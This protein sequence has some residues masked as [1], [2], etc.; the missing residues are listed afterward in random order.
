M[1]A[2]RLNRSKHIRASLYGPVSSGEVSIAADDLSRG[3]CQRQLG[4]NPGNTAGSQKLVEML[5][6]LESPRALKLH[7]NPMKWNSAF[8]LVLIRA[9]R[10]QL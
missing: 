3:Q 8:S 5:A 10:G 6:I 7:R 9:Y 4:Q 2:F 1:N